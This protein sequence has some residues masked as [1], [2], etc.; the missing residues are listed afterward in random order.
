M[1]IRTLFVVISAASVLS[2]LAVPRSGHVNEQASRDQ[3]CDAIRSRLHLKTDQFL[4][5]RRDEAL[6]QKLGIGT[7]KAGIF[8]Y[9][10]SRV[11]DEIKEH[12]VIVRHLFTDADPT[13]I[14]AVNAAAG[15]IYYIHGF[16]DSG[17]EFDK[18]MTA[19]GSKLGGPEQAESVVDFYREVNPEN[20][21]ITPISSLLELK[22]AAERQCQAVPFDP[23]EKQFEAWWKQAKASYAT[24]PFRQTTRRAR[25]GYVV[26]WA[27]L[28]SPIS[29]FCGGAPVRVALELGENGQVRKLSFTSVRSK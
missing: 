26:E 5:I 14:V 20:R 12:G 28:S 8:I 23:S 4:G 13:Y 7:G 19:I 15:S 3:V 29:G 6:E 9:R 22:Q 24:V 11:G 16:S 2:A 17:A 1:S 10:L 25:K 21:L 27:V 18:M